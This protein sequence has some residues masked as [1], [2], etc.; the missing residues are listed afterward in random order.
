VIPPG[1]SSRA[2]SSKSL[3]RRWR[4]AFLPAV[5]DVLALLV[6]QGELCVT[7]LSAFDAWSRGGGAEA[8]AAVRSARQE[9]FA[10]RRELQAALQAALSTPVDQED[11]YVLAERADRVLEV[12]RNAVREAE[13]L[14][15]TPDAHAATMSARL[16]EGIQA[17]VAGFELLVKD[18]EEAGRRA[19][20]ASD[21]VHRVEHDYREAMAELLQAD[22]L[23]VVFAGQ[24]LYRRYLA[25][26]EAIVAVADR[27]WFVVLRGA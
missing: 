2:S 20:A 13:V 22:D 6:A 11:L 25:L 23:R 16:A 26:A 7:G 14:G 17:L 10:A 27:L 1:D 21:A 5:P 15:W 4:R 3:R 19:D 9:A 12:A 8:A 18:P 24:D